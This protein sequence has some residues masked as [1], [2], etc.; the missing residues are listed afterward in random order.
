MKSVVLL[1]NLLIVS[2]SCAGIMETDA[3]CNNASVY[4]NC[5]KDLFV[6]EKALYGMEGNK[7]N[8]TNTFYPSRKRSTAFVRVTYMFNDKSGELSDDCNI[9]FWWTSGG[10]LLLQAPTFFQFSS[11][12]FGSEVDKLN[13]LV[14]TLPYEC[15]PVGIDENGKCSCE[16]NDNKLLD[17]LTQQV[18]S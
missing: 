14:L 12:F 3:I 6:L 2:S 4:A 11:L 7:L 1:C 8:L 18:Y 13:D 10:F 9:T 15:Q 17:V 16:G 5:P